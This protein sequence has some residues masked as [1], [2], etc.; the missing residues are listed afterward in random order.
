M[1]GLG[2]GGYCLT[3]DQNLVGYRAN[4]F[5]RKKNN[6]LIFSFNQNQ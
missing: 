6:F 1:P 4:F 3:K 2:V 5:E